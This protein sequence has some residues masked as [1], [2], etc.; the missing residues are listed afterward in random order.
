MYHVIRQDHR[1]KSDRGVIMGINNIVFDLDG[2]LL[3][4]E[5]IYR[6]ASPLAAD[7]IGYHMSDAQFLYMRSLGD[8]FI[9]DYVNSVWGNGFDLKRFIT[10]RNDIFDEYIKQES[11]QVKPGVLQ[12][13]RALKSKGLNLAIATATDEKRAYHYINET[14]LF[15]YFDQIIY[16]ENMK[17]GKPAPDI[18]LFA[19]SRLGSRPADTLAVEDSPNGILSAYSAGCAVAAIPDLTAL[20]PGLSK[21]TTFQCSDMSELTDIIADTP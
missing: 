10:I 9:S 6:F 17:C 18:Y 19:C 20:T 1:K 16:A 8:P 7:Q 12:T 13:L 5:K 11:I 14:D 15:E 21:L 3:D 4:T 2:T